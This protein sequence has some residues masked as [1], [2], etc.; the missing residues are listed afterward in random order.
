[1]RC[2]VGQPRSQQATNLGRPRSW[3]LVRCISACQK[4]IECL[5]IILPSYNM[6]LIT[7]CHNSALALIF[8]W[9]PY[10]MSC[11]PA[12]ISASHKSRPAEIMATCQVHSA[13]QKVIECLYII[14]PSSYNMYL[15]TF[16]HNSA[17]AFI[18]HRMMTKWDVMLAGRPR[19]QQ[20]TNLS[21]PRSWQLIRCSDHDRRS[22][23]AYI[24]SYRDHG[25]LSA[26]RE[27]MKA[28][29]ELCQKVIKY[30]L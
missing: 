25:N 21:R 4:V 28:R 1:M 27:K 15:I 2:H 8:G 24:S 30:I 12:E 9:W 20:A 11:Q 17:L 16:W 29:A 22:V 14:L 13:C 3:H 5:Y 18:L 19:S 23:S 7:F 10:E 6:Y 26:T